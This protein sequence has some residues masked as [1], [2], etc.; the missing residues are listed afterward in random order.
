MARLRPGWD[1]ES[2]IKA[3]GISGIYGPAEEADR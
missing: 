3:I 2:M 1:L